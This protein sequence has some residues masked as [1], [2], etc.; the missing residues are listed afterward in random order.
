MLRG[1]PGYGVTIEGDRWTGVH[2]VPFT[3]T[4]PFH[5]P[6][7]KIAEMDAQGHRL[8]RGLLPAAAVLL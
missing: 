4:A 5:D 2:H 3:I 8:G 6:A 1:D 7:A